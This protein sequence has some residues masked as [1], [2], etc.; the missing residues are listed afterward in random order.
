MS[1]AV[2]FHPETTATTRPQADIEWVGYSLPHY[3]AVRAALAAQCASYPQ[4]AL[5]RAEYG[6][7]AAVHAADYLDSLEQLSRDQQPH[8]APRLSIECQGLAYALPGYC[9]GLGGMCAAIDAF[10]AGS[11][12]RAYCFSLVGHHAHADW[13]HGYC[14][15]NPLAAAVRYA[16]SQDFKRVLIVDWDIH[17]GDGTQAIF[18]HDPAVFH[19]SIHSVVDLYMAK[20]S[21]LQVATVAAAAAV[22]HC[23]LPVLDRRF[24]AAL[25]EQVGITGP[26][27]C[28]DQTS[29]ALE[30]VLLNLPW[31]PDL[32]ALFS[33]YDAHHQDCGAQI[34][35]W[36]TDDFRALT[37]LICTAA[38]AAPVLSVHGGGY[39]LPSTVAAALAHIEA[40][41]TAV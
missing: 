30:H 19:I 22:G 28:A 14:L 18:A 34:T 29:A 9:Y 38:G 1:F 25:I 8:V 23:N 2:Y 24:D 37:K 17:H 31:Q 20:A 5:R 4:L 32:V 11:L 27:L 21:S 15:L 10:R 33:G 41:K 40:L 39:Y 6:L 12:K 35:D 3:E 16:Q 7:F 36:S 13:G 26:F